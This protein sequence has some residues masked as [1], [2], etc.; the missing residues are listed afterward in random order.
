MSN[1]PSGLSR[2][3]K[4]VKRRN[5]HRSLAIYAGTAFIILEAATIIF[6]RWDLPDWSIDLVLWLLILGAVIN[7]FV[8][9]VFD[10]TPQGLEKTKPI[11]EVAESE[12]RSDS[13]GWKA[14]TYLSLVVIIALIVLNTVG[15]PKQLQAG[16]IQSLVILPFDN[17]TGDDQLEYFVSGM[18]SSLIGDMGRI[19]GLR[20]LGKTSSN[21]YQDVDLSA[22]EI[23]KE[24]EVDA[25]VEATVMCVG[26]S[27][28][29]QVRVLSVFPEEKQLWIADYKE[30]KGQILNLYNHITKQIA[31]EVKVGLT[32][33]EE[34]QLEESRTVDPA[35]LDAYMKGQYYWELL[36][37]DSV[38]RTLEYFQLAT[39]LDPEWADPWAGLALAWG[40]FSF[41]EILPA[42]STN[43]M[44]T[45]FL[46]RALELNP[47]SAKA[48]FVNA[49]HAVWSEWDW[50]KG[51]QEFLKSLELNPNDALTRLYYAHLLMILRRPDEAL[52]QATLGLELDPLKGIV[53]FLYSM[54]LIHTGNY[55]TAIDFFEKILLTK[56]DSP[57]ANSSILLPYYLTGDY[58][59]WMQA[60]I[61]KVKWSDE[62]KAS[63][64]G[65]FNEEG[66]IAAIV[67][68]FSL[69]E[70]YSPE[71]CY[72]SDGIK[73]IRYFHLN[74]Y[75][76]VMD[77]Y[78]KMYE[79]ISVDMAYLAT[80]PIYEQMK[81]NA[82]YLALL[83]KMKLPLPK[84]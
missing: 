3:W 7:V 68:M 54:V 2:F 43:S 64:V 82:R 20:V 50:E 57:L 44:K 79:T 55:Q 27:I 53:H 40:M 72:M 32:A 5:V 71:D 81:D 49:T 30:E 42:S 33:G 16:D 67:E 34:R 31:D 8:A 41:Y 73:M 14:A 25:V 18:H 6:P 12:K 58:E 39:E 78:D 61:R 10:I 77:Y 80:S 52:Q 38:Q 74:N 66:H 17:F 35:A 21:K 37:R 15:G 1:K 24:L 48:H 36:N 69:N 29:L 46:N 63:V 65:A 47:N 56:P 11:E 45:K 60:W 13:K 62:A 76:R 83:K 4:E 9:W 84:D 75:E 22:P 70:K 51:E 19:G 28:C 23:A 59:K 26:D